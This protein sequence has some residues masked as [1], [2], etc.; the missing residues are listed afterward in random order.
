MSSA[1]HNPIK[2][3][4]WQRR[5]QGV[6]GA[7]V[8]FTSATGA[9]AG[10]AKHASTHT[11]GKTATAVTYTTASK[12]GTPQTLAVTAEVDLNTLTAHANNPDVGRPGTAADNRAGVG[13][14]EF[15]RRNADGSIIPAGSKA[16]LVMTV[17][18]AGAL[19][20]YVGAASTGTAY[21][22]QL[23]LYNEAAWAESLITNGSGADFV[24]GTTALNA[25][26]ITVSYDDL[27]GIQGA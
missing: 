22:P 23:D 27:N 4:F 19:H 13:L 21:R 9:G 5:V 6:M 8:S 24:V 15:E 17:D 2:T 12:G 20:A 3:A 7:S 26:S 18:D 16:W 14:N 1:S 11:S 25:G 10:W